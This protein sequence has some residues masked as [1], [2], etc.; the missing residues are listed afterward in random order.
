M[1][2]FLR[3]AEALAGIRHPNILPFLGA[4]ILAPTTFWLICEYMQGGTL[5]K[6]IHGDKG[7]RK[8]LLQRLQYALEV[9]IVVVACAQ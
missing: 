5:A 3:E 4:C 8:P 9:G 6:C 2:S 7:A 1:I